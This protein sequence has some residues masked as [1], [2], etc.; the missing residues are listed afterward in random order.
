MSNSKKDSSNTKLIVGLATVSIFGVG[1]L[2]YSYFKSSQDD[3]EEK[4]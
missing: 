2:A 3:G 1:V 4:G